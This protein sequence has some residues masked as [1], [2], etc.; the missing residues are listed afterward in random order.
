MLLS[1]PGL[2]PSAIVDCNAMTPRN[3][4]F[5][6]AMVMPCALT[7]AGR[8]GVARVTRF[9]VWTAAMSGL[10]PLSK[11]R[12]ICELPSEEDAEVK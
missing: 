1:S 4:A 11:V 7:S 8:R 2:G 3:P 10:V 6:L 9:W 5:A 12:V